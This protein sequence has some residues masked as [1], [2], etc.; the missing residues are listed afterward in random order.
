[1]LIPMSGSTGRKRVWPRTLGVMGALLLTAYA[2]PPYAG[3]STSATSS[4]NPGGA[5]RQWVSR[6]PLNQARAGLNVEQVDGVIFAIGGFDSDNLYGTTEARR[7]AGPG[8]WHYVAPMPTARADFASAVVNGLIYAAGGYDDVDNSSVVETY[9][10]RSDRWSTSRPLPQPRGGAAGASLGGLF[11]V[12]GGYIT[13]AVGDDQLVASVLAYDPQKNTWTRI[14]PMH[15]A[16]ERFRLVAA[17]GYLYAIGGVNLNGQSLTAVERYDPRSNIWK[18]IQP[19]KE[20]RALPGAVA[21]TIAGRPVI[22]VVGG[23]EFDAAGDNVGPRRTTEVLNLGT[24]NWT[25]LD[26]LLDHGRAGLDCALAADGTVLAIGGGTLV[27]GAN[28]FEADVDAL[29][30]EPRDLG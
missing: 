3:A 1:M 5:T 6:P 17:G 9:N 10:P 11:F 7:A 15:T 13:P 18:T 24:G 14:A 30:F 12:A 26:V 2:A 21:T 29:T 27:D 4:A 22:V 16:R 20:S 28:V 19:L 23:A 25:T 8:I